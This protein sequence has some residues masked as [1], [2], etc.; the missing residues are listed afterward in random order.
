MRARIKDQLG[1]HA[2]E[3]DGV[4]IA[5][6]DRWTD[7]EAARHY[8]AALGKDVDS[9]ITTKSVGDVPLF[10]NT[11]TGRLLLQFKSFAL[12]SHQKVLL[13]GLQESPTNFI[14]GMVGMSALGMLAAYARAWRGGEDRM[15]RFSEAAENPGYLIGEALDLTGIFAV[16][17]E[18]ANTFEKVAGVNPVKDPLKRMFPGTSQAGSSLRYQSRGVASTFLGP[19]AGLIDV[20]SE[21][22]KLSAMTAAGEATT[23]QK[24]RLADQAVQLVPYY[25]YPGMREMVNLLRSGD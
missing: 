19:S 11:P 5:H 10:A 18:A 14:S 22:A 24:K 17:M 13:R 20:A 6:S 1:A 21:V 3:L 2:E 12:A 9:V 16:P 15:K 7:T 4:W 25:S 8:G 23:G